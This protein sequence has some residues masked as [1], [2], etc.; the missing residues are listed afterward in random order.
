MS[1]QLGDC[2]HC[3]RAVVEGQYINIAEMT[4]HAP[5][6]KCNRCEKNLYGKQFAAV[7]DPK[8]PTWK[9]YC[10]ECDTLNASK[11][12]VNYK[13][14]RTTD[15][16]RKNPA[17]K[18]IPKPPRE[19]SP[20][21]QP[22]K[23]EYSAVQET[24]SI[25]REQEEARLRA[26]RLRKL[27]DNEKD[28]KKVQTRE[29]LD[30]AA[31]VR[32]RQK[33]L[34]QEEEERIAALNRKDAEER[35]RMRKETQNYQVERK[36]RVEKELE[37][38]NKAAQVAEIY[39]DQPES[40]PASRPYGGSSKNTTSTATSTTSPPPPPPMSSS[41]APPPPPPPAPSFS[42]APPPPPPPP[43]LGGGGGAKR[44]PARS[45]DDDGGSSGGGAVS[46]IL[47]SGA[48]ED[49]GRNALLDSIRGFRANRLRPTDT[50]DRSSPVIDSK[51]GDDGGG[52]G[53]GGG[54]R[55]PPGAVGNPMA[56]MAAAMANRRK[57]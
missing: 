54:R 41:A 55:L 27:E 21:P 32:Q 29:Q 4:Y 57:Q 50:N 56:A 30:K 20:P 8:T 47:P 19:P 18:P 38:P 53:G 33:D 42:S 40:S 46:G 12:E 45:N 34:N 44:A 37:S 35:S 26:E 10:N 11:T 5:C 39:Y 52:G 9:I 31:V 49:T 2:W 48:A 23:R 28:Q 6:F 15:E 24:T 22:K 25:F 16:K 36:S 3:K 7:G 14:D 13:D 51:G 43:M 1:K 17:Q